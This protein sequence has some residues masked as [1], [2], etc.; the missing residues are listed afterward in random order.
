MLH[1]RLETKTTPYPFPKRLKPCPNKIFRGERV[2]ALIPAK[3]MKL[4]KYLHIFALTKYK[5]K[6]SYIYGSNL[7][8]MLAGNSILFRK[9]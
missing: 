1:F 2:F 5:T 8:V 7:I 6:F 9:T 4:G 3:L